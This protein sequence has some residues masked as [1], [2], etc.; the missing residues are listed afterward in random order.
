MIV[1]AV[2]AC[3][4]PPP[5]PKHRVSFVA[6]SDAE[7]LPGVRV[8]AWGRPLGQTG[9]DGVLRVDLEGLDGTSVPVAAECPPG[10]RTPSRLPP[11]TLRTFRGLDPR[12]AERGIEVAIDCPPA[13]RV[14]AVVV[15]AAGQSDLPVLLGGREVAR[16]DAGGVA[17]FSLRMA[18]HATFRVRLDTSSRPDL[19]P[20]NPGATFTVPDADEVFLYDQPF[21]V[22]VRRRPTRRP[23]RPPEPPPPPGPTLPIRIQ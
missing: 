5:P 1:V 3:E 18:P 6:R 12:R 2:A 8:S 7:P 9:R 10:H 16:T 23:R 20:Q 19:A 11:L 14:A 22:R 17:H 21:E 13:E 4:P 15:R